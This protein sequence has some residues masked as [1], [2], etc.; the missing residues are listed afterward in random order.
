MQTTQSAPQKPTEVWTVL[1]GTGI[2]LR[3]TRPEQI[4][5]LNE[6][7]ASLMTRM[8]GAPI[9]IDW[10]AYI[11]ADE[12]QREELNCLLIAAGILTEVLAHAS[13]PTV[14]GIYTKTDHRLKGYEGPSLY[15]S[16][17][18]F[19]GVHASRHATEYMLKV[20]P[21]LAAQHDALNKEVSGVV[22]GG[23]PEYVLRRLFSEMVVPDI[24]PAA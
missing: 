9:K 10:D 11:K 23:R 8:D 6:R 19:T 21:A 18:Y 14:I 20:A 7:H 15:E 5:R 1:T 24:L 2:P 3:S 13:A 12:G 4:R 17:L 16:R 22:V